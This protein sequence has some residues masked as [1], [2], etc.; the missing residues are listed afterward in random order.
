[1]HEL[2][3]F[4]QV[5]TTINTCRTK[6]RGVGPSDGFNYST[7]R[8]MAKVRP[9]V[10]GAC[11][12]L[13]PALCLYNAPCWSNLMLRR[14]VCAHKLT[15]LA[16]IRLSVLHRASRKPTNEQSFIV[17]QYLEG[18]AQLLYPE[19]ADVFPVSRA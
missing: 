3:A 8:L 2:G 6:H 4:L 18:K 1:M 12:H 10:L 15:C 11:V 14:R 19:P 13:Q 17:P 16:E 7:T 9:C 5:R